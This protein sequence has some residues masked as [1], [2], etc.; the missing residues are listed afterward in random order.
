MR[1]NTANIC[2]DALIGVL[3]GTDA[4]IDRQEKIAASV[5]SADR[6][7]GE[8]V[9]GFAKSGGVDALMLNTNYHVSYIPCRTWDTSWRKLDGTRGTAESL[10]AIPHWSSRFVRAHEMGIEPYALA[11][12]HA[13]ESGLQCWFSVRMNEF[14]YLRW[15]ETSATLWL[16]HPEY[17]QAADLP[18]DY[19]H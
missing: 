18:F 1:L 13:R 7:I 16:E 9:R 15:P 2:A 19:R 4:L 8:W 5:E 11:L 12:K 14:H 6:A 17:R 3:S 10:E